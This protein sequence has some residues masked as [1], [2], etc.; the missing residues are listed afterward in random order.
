MNYPEN[1]KYTKE[2]EWAKADGPAVLVGITDFAQDSLG[3]VVYVE[4]PPVGKELLAGKEFG[5]VESV[6]SVSSLFAPIN[7]T[8]VEA[9]SALEG[10][11]ALINTSPYAEGWIVK[12]KPANP[13]DLNGLLSATEYQKTLS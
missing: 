12:V 1:L 7:G 10:N 9:N 11:P 3:D 4:L 2:H 8:V 5:V 6:K 13:A